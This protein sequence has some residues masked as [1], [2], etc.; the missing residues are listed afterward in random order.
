MLKR[1]NQT[2]IP[3][4]LCCVVGFASQ[5][6]LAVEKSFIPP[7]EVTKAMERF[8]GKGFKIKKY[9]PGPIGLVGVVG[10]VPEKIAG[11]SKSRQIVYFIDPSGRYLFSGALIDMQNN[12]ELSQAAAADYQTEHPK[13]NTRKTVKEITASDLESLAFIEQQ[14]PLKGDCFY[15]LVDQG[16]PHCR[17]ELQTI[18]EL[19][20]DRT[21][22][23]VGVRWVPV[24]LGNPRSTTSAS[25][26]LGSGSDAL[27]E[28]QRYWNM[29]KSK[30]PNI[31]K[32]IKEG[33]D[34]AKK[35]LTIGIN[36]IDRNLDLMEKFNIRGVPAGFFVRDGQVKM[37]FRG[38]MD[39]KTLIKKIQ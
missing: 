15:F 25:L 37:V 24:S 32:V 19:I 7:A 39:G 8:T 29:D 26:V 18:T 31:E 14:K 6:V 33:G 23:N 13:E 10:K 3:F 4:L 9:F 20:K 12:I 17:H 36:R 22:K 38:Y 28:F 2:I 5:T 34:T 30:V 11:K 1:I 16:C 35:K 21:M 27:A